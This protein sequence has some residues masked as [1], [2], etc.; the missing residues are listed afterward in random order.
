MTEGIQVVSNRNISKVTVTDVEDRPG[1]AAEVFG[2]LG[3]RGFNVEL[4][5]STGGREGHA[6][7]SLAVSRSQEAQVRDLLDEIRE[8][9]KG[10]DIQINSKVALIS[11]VGH[12]LSRE[13]GLAGRMFAALSSRGINIEVIS[14]SMSSVTCMIDEDRLEA[15]EQALRVEFD[16]HEPPPAG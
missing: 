14:T 9:V 11:L 7:I 5:V 2:T 16:V 10:R 4:V 8:E 1:M 3:A 13:V 6:D 15:A 12:A